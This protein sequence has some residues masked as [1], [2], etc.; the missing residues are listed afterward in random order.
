MRKLI[1]TEYV[2]LD[3]VMEA[4]NLWSFRFWNDEAAKYKFDEL[5]ASDAMLLGRVTYQG[6]AAAW[7][8]MKDEANFADRMN[9]I[10][11]YV[12]SSTLEKA[13]WNNSTLLKRDFINEIAELKKQPGKEILLEG[14]ADLFNALLEHQLI[15]EVKLMLHPVFWGSGKHLFKKG[16]AA[17]A[18]TLNEVRTFKS[19]IVILNYTPEHPDVKE[20]K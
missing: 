12:V 4:P 18:M 16:T 6:F 11:K 1:A 3:G 17:A 14:S 5:F 9:T 10:S 2:T 15:D 7:P 19:G 13:E 20:N 8:T